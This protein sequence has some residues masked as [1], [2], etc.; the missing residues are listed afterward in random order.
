MTQSQQAQAYL[1]HN[2]D[3]YARDLRAIMPLLQHTAQDIRNGV[4]TFTGKTLRN[5]REG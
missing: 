2:S 3:L 1:Q 4:F 5:G